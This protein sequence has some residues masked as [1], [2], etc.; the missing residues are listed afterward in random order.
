MLIQ[1][2]KNGLWL[3]VFNA[4]FNNISPISW[5]NYWWWKPEYAEKTTDLSQVTDKL[6]HM[7]G[8]HLARVG[9]QLTTLVVIGI[10]CTDSCNPNYRTITPTTAPCT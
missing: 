10:G 5:R 8:V 2:K 9:F 1:Q 4:A 7:Y 6:D 3:M